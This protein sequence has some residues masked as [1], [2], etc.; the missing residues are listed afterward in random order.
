[1]RISFVIGR[2]LQLVFRPGQSISFPY[3][4]CKCQ[5]K[6][7]CTEG[8]KGKAGN[9]EQATGTRQQGTGKEGFHPCRAVLCSAVPCAGAA[10]HDAKRCG[11]PRGTTPHATWQRVAARRGRKGPLSH[12]IAFRHPHCITKLH[13]LFFFAPIVCLAI[14]VSQNR[15]CLFFFLH[16]CRLLETERIFTIMVA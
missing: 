16:L 9:R 8:N 5:C 15:P 6:I 7:V 2:A 3:M 4:Q 13:R 12:Y 10:W 14:F 11:M 1:M